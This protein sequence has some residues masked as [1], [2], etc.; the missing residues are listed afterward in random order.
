MKEPQIGDR[1]QYDCTAFGE[2]YGNC[3][4]VVGIISGVVVLEWDDGF[5]HWRHWFLDQF[6]RE[7]VPAPAVNEWEGDLELL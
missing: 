2:R 1:F 4:T 7:W 3:A 5:G 6:F